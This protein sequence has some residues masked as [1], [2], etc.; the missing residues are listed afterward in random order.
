MNH[1]NQYNY[2]NS[3]YVLR[4]VNTEAITTGKCVIL[5][6]DLSKWRSK[7]GVFRMRSPF[8]RQRCVSSR[9]DLGVNVGSQTLWRT[10][11]FS[12]SR[13][14]LVVPTLERH[15]VLNLT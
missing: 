12:D 5:T 3:V 4:W 7:R 9:N 6:G 2:Y 8:L 1:F 13:Y 10:S 14:W 11:E 15:I